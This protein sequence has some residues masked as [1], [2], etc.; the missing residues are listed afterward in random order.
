MSPCGSRCRSGQFSSILFVVVMHL[1][2]AQVLL[3]RSMYEWM[4]SRAKPRLHFLLLASLLNV[5][6]ISEATHSSFVLR[7]CEKP[8]TVVEQSIS[9]EETRQ[10]KVKR[11]KVI[12][13][14]DEAVDLSSSSASRIDDSME[15]LESATTRDEHCNRWYLPNELLAQSVLAH[16]VAAAIHSD[17]PSSDE[18]SY[19]GVM[20]RI[21]NSCLPECTSGPSHEVL[22]K[23]E[24]WTRVAHSRRGL[25]RWSVPTSGARRI[26]TRKALVKDIVQFQRSMEANCDPNEKAEKIRT[27]SRAWS[28]ADRKSVV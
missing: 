21:Y 6:Q 5:T 13:W 16:R 12:Q 1:W 14:R 10:I 25:E 2:K 23:L 4:T 20:E 27:R 26:K 11:P 28:Y 19:V 17:G 18:S 8:T 22:T 24:H 15:N 3:L 7:M 9:M